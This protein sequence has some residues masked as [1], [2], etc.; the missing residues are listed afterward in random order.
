MQLLILDFW[1]EDSHKLFIACAE[2]RCDEVEFLLQKLAQVSKER[3]C[4]VLFFIKGT[5]EQS[6]LYLLGISSEFPWD[7]ASCCLAVLGFL[8]ASCFGMSLNSKLYHP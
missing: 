5:F 6:G 7:R 2:N 4:L 1:Q 8:F 3:I